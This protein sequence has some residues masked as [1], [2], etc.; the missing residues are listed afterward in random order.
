[1]T[2]DI[3]GADLRVPPDP[4]QHGPCRFNK[5]NG[6]KEDCPNAAVLKGSACAMHL[7]MVGSANLSAGYD[8]MGK[9][10]L[11]TP[12]HGGAK[13]DRAKAKSASASRRRNRR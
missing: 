11:G 1:M 13:R 3:A 8:T 10:K 2:D 7:M 4:F 12:V 6:W 5:A 9:V